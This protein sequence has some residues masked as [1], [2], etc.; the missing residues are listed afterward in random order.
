MGPPLELFLA[1]FWAKAGFFMIL[2]G[3]SGVF[4][5]KSGSNL[6]SIFELFVIR[7]F[8]DF[9]R[10]FWEAFSCMVGAKRL[11]N[12]RFLGV[13]AMFGNFYLHN[14]KHTLLMLGGTHTNPSHV[15]FFWSLLLASLL[16]SFL[17]MPVDFV[18]PREAIWFQNG[19]QTGSLKHEQQTVF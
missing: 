12:V 13:V 2:G 10:P 9:W 11:P 7:F 15:G 6:G 17:Q 5:G 4:R 14:P 18:V 19:G 8:I 1:A 3:L 16:G